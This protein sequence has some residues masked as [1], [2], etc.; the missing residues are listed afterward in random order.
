MQREISFTR[1]QILAPLLKFALPV[2]GALILQAMYGAVDLMV[3][4]HFGV[5][6]DVSAVSTGSQLMHTIT[7]VITGLSMGTTVLLGQHI[8]AGEDDRAGDVIGGAIWL[9]GLLGIAVA[10][11]VPLLARPLCALMQAPEEAFRQTVEYVSICAAGALFIVAYN[12]LGSVFRGMGDSRTPLFTVLVACVA[13]I[14]GDLLF[15]GGFGM[16]AAGAALAT[17]LAQGVSVALCLLVI[18]RR[19]LPFSFSRR[20]LR[21]QTA[22][23]ARTLRLGAPIALQDL[24]VSI[25]FLVILAIV[26]SLGLVASAGVGVAEKLCAFIMLVPSAFSQSLSAFVA[27]NIGAGQAGR[28]RRAMVY[29]MV[30]SFLLGCAM[31]WAAYLHGEALG[32]IFARDAK[33]IA[34]GADYLRAYAIDTLLV[35]F[36]FCYLGFFNGCGCTTFVLIQGLVGAFCVRIPVSWLMSR[37]SWATLFHIGLSTPASTVVQILLCTAYFLHLR[38]IQNASDRDLAENTCAL[39]HTRL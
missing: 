19:G 35:S 27:Q 33:V 11:A 36:L 20:N 13:N 9:F 34:A 12:V 25:S 21:P 39:P 6:A 14:L 15:V 4:G 17:I 23:L 5:P 32:A 7:L 38:R 37:Q 28:A 2:L 3:V 18:R 26:N 22:V 1:G 31:A 16:A 29:G 10:I 8:G 24:L 30:A